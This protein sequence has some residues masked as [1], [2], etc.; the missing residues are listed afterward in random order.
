M[1]PLLL[2]LLLCGPVAAGPWPQA[3]GRTYGFA[4]YEDGDEPY[5][6]VYVER[7]LPHGLTL[8]L[9]AGGK[10]NGL[11]ASDPDP[12][13]EGRL[14]AFLRLPVLSSEAERAERPG[15]LAPWLAA[16]ELGLGPD[17]ERDGDTPLRASV[18]LT[19]GRGLQTR[20]GDGWTTFDLR[21]TAGGGGACRLNAASVLGIKP[22]ERLALEMGLFAEREDD[23]SWAVAPTAQYELGG[24]GAARFGVSLKDGGE[25]VLR[26][27]WA[28]AF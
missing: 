1:R 8:G 10:L 23:T 22:T 26:L 6:S 18:G 28:R 12:E 27:G 24:T 4:G 11:L 15:W 7:G 5:S 19:V 21:L 9:D 3:E 20:L 14:R 2:L 25:T 17:L 13:A 16:V